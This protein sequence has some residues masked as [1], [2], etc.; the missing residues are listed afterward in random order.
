ME[1]KSTEDLARYHLPLSERQ[2][3]FGTRLVYHATEFHLTSFALAN[4]GRPM[5]SQT[6]LC[7][8]CWRG[9][10]VVHPPNK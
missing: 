1:T 6:W 4:T 7:Y 8:L 9:F 5:W 3:A 10:E 2:L